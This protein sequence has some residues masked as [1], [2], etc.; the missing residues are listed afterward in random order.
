MEQTDELDRAELGLIGATLQS[1]GRVITELDFDPT[2]FRHPVMEQTWR[3]MQKMVQDGKPLDP[4]T[5]THALGN[6]DMPVDP[7][8]IYQSLDAAPS[9]A[10]AAYYANIVTEHAARRR[11]SAVGR[12]IADLAGQPG[13]IDAIIDEARKK[14]DTSAKVNTTSPVEYVWETIDDTIET[15]TQG[16]SYIETPWPS[17]NRSIGG[18]RRRAGYTGAGRHGV[19]RS[20]IG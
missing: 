20:G 10:S 19:G 17:R 2:D 6:S 15:F 3:V 5:V 7:S 8:L 11:L 9:A 18:L 4:V 1:A 13:S 12:A 16:D 14:L